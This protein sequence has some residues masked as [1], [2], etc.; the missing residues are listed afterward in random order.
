MADGRLVHHR[1]DSQPPILRA[2]DLLH[3]NGRSFAAATSLAVLIYAGHNLVASLIAYGGG[4][5]IDRTGPKRVF[6]SAA[7]VYIVA[8]ALFGL[9]SGG[10]VLLV[11]AFVL[12]GAGI[13]LAETAESSLVARLLP[14]ELRGSGFGVLGGAQ[15]FG[16]LLSSA[17]VGLL[18]SLIS[19]AA[20]FLY[21]A[22]WMI[23]AAGATIRSRAITD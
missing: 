9:V 4:H 20:G 14:D 22:G 3:A 5:W 17:I 16:G 19:P 6:A 13:G 1:F 7:G 15:A 10:W 8:Y 2:T 12:A 21:A 11:L 18:W 23:V